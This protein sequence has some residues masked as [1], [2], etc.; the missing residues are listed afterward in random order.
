MNRTLKQPPHL[1]WKIL[2]QENR[3]KILCIYRFSIL[4]TY[5]GQCEKEYCFFRPRKSVV[6]VQ[7]VPKIYM[8]APF[9]WPSRI[10]I[11]PV[12]HPYKKQKQK[13]QVAI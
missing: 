6:T 11:A 1:V 10:N 3:H 8:D 9:V 2:F 12:Y 4:I 7:T 5:Q 13:A